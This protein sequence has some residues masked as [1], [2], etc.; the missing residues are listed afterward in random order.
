MLF[1]WARRNVDRL[2]NA[3]TNK[4]TAQKISRYLKIIRQT[5]FESS[6][7]RLGDLLDFGQVFKV[8]GNK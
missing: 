2:R 4:L 1:E 6:E 3:K 7:T 5:G 8:F